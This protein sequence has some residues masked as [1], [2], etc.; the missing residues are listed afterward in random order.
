MNQDRKFKTTENDQAFNT[1]IKHFKKKK[2]FKD[3]KCYNCDKIGH[4]A[5]DC[6]SPQ[7]TRNNKKVNVNISNKKK[8]EFIFQTSEQ[9]IKSRSLWLLDSG[10]TN[11]ICCS[12]EMF[13]SLTEY[14]SFVQ[15]G[16]GKNLEV[17]GRGNIK[18]QTIT[19]SGMIINLTISGASYMYL[20]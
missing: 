7:K 14:N 12:I 16:D 11:H 3:I 15:V 1:K 5:S 20:N 9:D 10:A 19:T 6:K 2:F 4:Y 8:E 17:N 18:L 13:Q